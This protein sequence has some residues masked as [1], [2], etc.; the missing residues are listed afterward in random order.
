MPLQTDLTEHFELTWKKFK[1]NW[2]WQLAIFHHRLFFS[3]R[4]ALQW[5]VLSA[6]VYVYIGIWNC[7]GIQWPVTVYLPNMYFN[8]R[9]KSC[10]FFVFITLN[11]NQKKWEKNGTNIF[12]MCSYAFGYCNCVNTILNWH[13]STCRHP[14]ML[15]SFCS[16]YVQ[17]LYYK[18][19]KNGQTTKNN[20]RLN[21][22]RQ[23]HISGNEKYANEPTAQNLST[24][25]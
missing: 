5:M 22:L 2:I 21:K 16:I 12:E 19:K 25:I 13:P 20:K 9:G 23:P 7:S 17:S 15:S 3:I 4:F 1:W 6:F 11:F 14:L 24:Y 10:F 18:L 8:P